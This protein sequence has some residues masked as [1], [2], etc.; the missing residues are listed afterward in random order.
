MTLPTLAEIVAFESERTS[1]HVTSPAVT[2]ATV[3][4][5]EVQVAVAVRFLV[6]P[7]AKVP[8]AVSCTLPPG[9]IS[10]RFEGVMVMDFSCGA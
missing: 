10:P 9:G 5:L 8:V 2:V 4:A 1:L 3:E 6:A 7:D